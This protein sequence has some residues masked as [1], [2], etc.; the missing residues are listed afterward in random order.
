M[1]GYI[2]K[3]LLPGAR[4][5]LARTDA[6]GSWIDDGAYEL[7][8]APC[9]GD[10]NGYLIVYAHGN[11]ETL[12]DSAPTLDEIARRT[13]SVVCGVEYPGYG[14]HAGMPCTPEGCNDA[15][16]YA[17]RI[18]A[19]PPE[20]TI[21]MGRSIGT[22]PATEIAH[23]IGAAGLILLSPFLSLS[24]LLSWHGAPRGY[25]RGVIRGV[26]SSMLARRLSRTWNTRE[27]LREYG[28]GTLLIHGAEDDLIPAEHSNVLYGD[29]GGRGKMLY[30]LEGLGH[31]DHGLWDPVLRNCVRF[32]MRTRELRAHT[33]E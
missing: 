16:R 15:L 1:D 20:N 19:F 32:A 4:H 7:Y 24:E 9:R 3:Q 25:F 29:N 10:E 14:E 2:Q 31:N 8:I 12:R 5:T 6:T 21:V 23:E 27:T 13:G 33:N 28:G 30:I 22:G 26:L 18:M 11:M 17:I